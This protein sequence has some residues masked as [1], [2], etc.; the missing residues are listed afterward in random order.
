VAEE[1]AGKSIHQTNEGVLEIDYRVQC[2]KFLYVQPFWQYM[3]RPSGTG[4]I[5]N[6]NILGVNLGVTF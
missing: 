1:D 4:M 2:N 6:A 3:I 5:N